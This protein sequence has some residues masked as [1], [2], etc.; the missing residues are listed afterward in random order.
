MLDSVPLS[1]IRVKGSIEGRLRED[2]LALASL[3]FFNV[4]AFRMLEPKGLE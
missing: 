4:R 2:I 3:S 1:K